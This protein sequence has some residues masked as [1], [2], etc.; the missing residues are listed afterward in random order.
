VSAAERP[1]LSELVQLSSHSARDRDCCVA[2]KRER[3]APRPTVVVF[4]REGTLGVSAGMPWKGGAAASDQTRS[5]SKAALRS[6]IVEPNGA[7]RTAITPRSLRAYI[8]GLVEIPPRPRE[9]T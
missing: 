8:V 2:V 7:G 9:A 6:M 3:E 4:L 1:S 5:S